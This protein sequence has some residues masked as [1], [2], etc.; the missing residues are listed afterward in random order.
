MNEMEMDF[1]RHFI[2]VDERGR[3]IYAFSD[4]FTQPLETDILI[5]DK[6]GRHLRL[7]LDGVPTHENPVELIFDE[8][9]VPLLKWDAKNRKIARRTEKEIQADMEAIPAH[10]PLSPIPV[11]ERIKHL[12]KTT[13]YHEK[14]IKVIIGTLPKA[15]QAQLA[16]VQKSM[17]G[18]VLDE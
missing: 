7:I 18:E 10:E 9:N 2:R 6:G 16:Q 5:N 17:F 14:V 12:E 3:I 8:R 1:N 13:E 11:E 4:A 15:Q